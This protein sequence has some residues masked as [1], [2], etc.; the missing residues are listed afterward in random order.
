VRAQGTHEARPAFLLLHARLA[1]LERR[2]GTKG[3]PQSE[4]PFPRAGRADRG[5][6]RERRGLAAFAAPA[7]GDKHFRSESREHLGDRAPAEGGGRDSLHAA[8]RQFPL[9]GRA[10]AFDESV[11]RLEINAERRQRHRFPRR[12]FPEPRARRGRAREGR[13]QRRVPAARLPGEFDPRAGRLE[14]A[15]EALEGKRRSVLKAARRPRRTPVDAHLQARVL[16]NRGRG[17]RPR[18]EGARAPRQ[19]PVGLDAQE[20][21]HALHAQPLELRPLRARPPQPDDLRIPFDQAGDNGAEVDRPGRFEMDG[22]S[23]RAVLLG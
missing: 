5:A 22:E 15:F 1:L 6:Q 21:L 4:E 17:G 12:R 10:E 23:P 2:R 3:P 19:N 11:Q 14:R 18:R 8:A 20:K 16:G 13:R 7:D 9:L